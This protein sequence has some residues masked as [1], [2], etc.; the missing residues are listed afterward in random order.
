MP[1]STSKV[2]KKVVKAIS[3]PVVM[4]MSAKVAAIKS[5][6]ANKKKNGLINLPPLVL[7]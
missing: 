4:L 2:N 3:K 5:S 6:I 1:L 7:Y